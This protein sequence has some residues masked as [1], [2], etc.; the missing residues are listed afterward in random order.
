[1]PIGRYF[2]SGGYRTLYGD[3][4]G[5]RIPDYFRADFSVNIDGNH[6]VRQV[7]HNSWTLGVYNLTGR[8]NPFSVYYITEGGAINGYRLSIFGSAIPFITYNIR[9]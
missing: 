3:R 4:N 2:Y 7:F 8:R 6:K 9:F 1:V 5:H